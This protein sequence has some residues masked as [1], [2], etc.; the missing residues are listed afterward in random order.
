MQAVIIGIIPSY[1][2]KEDRYLIDKEYIEAIER[3]GGLPV[4]IPYLESD[5]ALRSV[6]N[7]IHGL[8][9]SGGGDLDPIHYGQ[10]PQNVKK[11]VPER[12]HVELFMTREAFERRIPIL[13]ICRGIQTL[14]VA[15]GGTLIQD[16]TDLQHY[17]DAEGYV[18]THTIRI[19]KD[20]L[21]AELLGTTET[22]VNSF[23]HQAVEEVAP[24]LKAT[25]WAAD[26]T[27]EAVESKDPSRFVLGVQFHIELLF[28]K[29]P[30]FFRI[31][32]AFVA[33]ARQVS[34]L[35]PSKGGHRHG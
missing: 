28:E 6:M 20:S 21:L 7:Q 19:A 25:A 32:E 8:L 33:Q 16:L 2:R 1:D 18:L 24:S 17:Q 31:F 27:I 22:R 9:L 10:E 3:A 26:G 4:L 35:E 13:G 23:H 29:H 11:L 12:D 14:N 5:E 30:Q 34:L 15:L